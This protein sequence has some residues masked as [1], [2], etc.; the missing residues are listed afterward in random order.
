MEREQENLKV[1]VRIRPLSKKEHEAI[2]SYE[3]FWEGRKRNNNRGKV[4]QAAL[5]FYTKY[6]NIRPSEAIK[7]HNHCVS[8]CDQ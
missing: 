8:V 7:I 3:A 5:N 4:A 1:I 6:H 2:D